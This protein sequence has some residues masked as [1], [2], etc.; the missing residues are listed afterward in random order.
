VPL[1][2]SVSIID[3]Y[4]KCHIAVRKDVDG[5]KDESGRTV[6]K[7]DPAAQPKG[8]KFAGA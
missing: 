3:A 2:R 1:L 5:R 7:D 8:P 4:E 6:I